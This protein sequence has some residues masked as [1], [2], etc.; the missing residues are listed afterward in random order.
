[1]YEQHIFFTRIYIPTLGCVLYVEYYV[2]LET[3]DPQEKKA[4][5]L[6]TTELMILVL[7]VVKLPAK[8]VS[9]WEKEENVKMNLPRTDALLLLISL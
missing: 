7:Y 9:V 1:M 8:T 6:Q 4:I 5:I 3:P 2:F